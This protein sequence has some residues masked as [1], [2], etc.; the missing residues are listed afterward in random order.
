MEYKYIRK[1]KEANT[2][3]LLFISAHKATYYNLLF[4]LFLYSFRSH[5]FN[6][7][8]D[9]YTGP[10]FP[11]HGPSSQSS[12]LRILLQPIKDPLDQ[13]VISG[14]YQIQ[15]R[16]KAETCLHENLI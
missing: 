9:F 6:P 5:N 15:T 1:A 16:K 3:F 14:I 8:P 11:F 13:M 10:K 7:G 4:H 2:I 12:Q